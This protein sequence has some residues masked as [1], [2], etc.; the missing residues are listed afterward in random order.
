MR[1]YK[2][3]SVIAVLA[4]VLAGCGGD[5][6]DAT[7]SETSGG[8]DDA[9]LSGEVVVAGGPFTLGSTDPWAYDNERPAHVV[10]LPPFR[11]DRALVTR[12]R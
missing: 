4:V 3:F 1:R 7:T 9:D 10:D 5:D 8:G 6:D 2:T 12:S 11:I